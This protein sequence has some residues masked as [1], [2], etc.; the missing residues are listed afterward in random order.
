MTVVYHTYIL[1]FSPQ[2]SY[3]ESMGFL[4]Q[5]GVLTFSFAFVFIWQNTL[6]AQYTLPILGF[7]I[8]VFLIVSARK[9]GFY[10]GN[11][12]D[13]DG[14]LIIFILNSVILLLIL[15][16]G[17]IFSN[18]FFLVYFLCFGISFVFRPTT[19]FVF[20]L[21]ATLIFIPDIIKHEDIS[22]FLR[23]GSIF[24]LS[25]LAMFFGKEFRQNQNLEEKIESTTD[26]IDKHVE[27]LIEDN[28]ISNKEKEK[29]EDILDETESLRNE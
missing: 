4:I 7:L 13:K 17:G 26:S 1:A 29:L 23:V 6:L 16:T 21:L 25:P 14:T 28:T 12:N 18:F 22:N 10:T 19:V 20:A 5:S 8:L 2:I 27:K 24:L 3:Y 11:Y 9:K 15:S